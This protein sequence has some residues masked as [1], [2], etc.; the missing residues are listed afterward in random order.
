MLVALTTTVAFAQEFDRSKYPYNRSDFG[1]KSP[2]DKVTDVN[3]GNTILC[4]LADGDHRVSLKEAFDAGISD[5]KIKKLAR[6]K[7]NVVWTSREI[8]RAK[9]R[10]SSEGF[11]KKLKDRGEFDGRRFN[12]HLRGTIATKQKY[13]IPLDKREEAFAFKVANLTPT[14]RVRILVSAKKFNE[15]INMVA[16]RYG[17]GVAKKIAKRVGGVFVPGAGWVLSGGLIGFDLMWW[18]FTGECEICDAGQYFQNLMKDNYE[19]Q[20]VKN[21]VPI[22][23]QEQEYLVLPTAFHELQEELNYVRS[24]IYIDP[25]SKNSDTVIHK[26][27]MKKLTEE[28]TKLKFSI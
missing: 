1:C 2:L 5:N 21:P 12:K 11:E 24:L 23:T 19:T 8:N 6:D 22:L 13:G 17:W 18:F 9:G 20:I 15:A 4:M 14:N 27:Y 28:L 25:W 26:E 7:N 10:L 16:I 3:T